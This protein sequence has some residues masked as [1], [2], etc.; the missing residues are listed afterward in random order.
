MRQTAGPVD[1]ECMSAQAI[2]EALADALA[3]SPVGAPELETVLSTE[4]AAKRHPIRLRVVL[5]W[6]SVLEL[7][8]AALAL[9][10]AV[11]WHAGD[12][13]LL[14]GAYGMTGSFALF[15]AL[16]RP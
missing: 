16:G 9:L 7:G 8:L 4:A 2:A 3:V 14:G 5:S 6:A 1:T 11:T 13:A 10:V 12:A 15:A